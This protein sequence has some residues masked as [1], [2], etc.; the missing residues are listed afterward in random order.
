MFAAIPAIVT[1]IALIV[2]YELFFVCVEQL[3]SDER[4]NDR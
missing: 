3:D 4:P 2:W 1:V